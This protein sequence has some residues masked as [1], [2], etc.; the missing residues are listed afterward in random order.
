V[1]PRSPDVCVD[2]QIIRINFAHTFTTNL[3]ISTVVK[4]QKSYLSDNSSVF[5]IYSS[6]VKPLDDDPKVETCRSLGEL[7]VK[8]YF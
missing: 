7:Y 3:T 6:H 1:L 8:V 2:I 4:G 5:Y